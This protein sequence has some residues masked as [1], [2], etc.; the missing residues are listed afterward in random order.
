MPR[1]KT[2]TNFGEMMLATPDFVVVVSL[3]REIELVFE[4]IAHCNDPH[5]LSMPECVG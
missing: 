2:L 3:Q 5:L 1:I 4:S